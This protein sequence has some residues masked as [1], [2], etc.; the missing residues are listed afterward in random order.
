MINDA[1]AAAKA[2][3]AV[4]A[5]LGIHQTQEREGVDRTTLDLPGSQNDLIKAVHAVG[6]P[7]VVVLINGGPLA[8]EWIAKNVSAI[9]EAFYPG[10]MGGD[11]IADI[12]MGKIS[13]GGR[14]PVT[15]YPS[16]F[17]K[18]RSM[19]DMG[20]RDGYGVTYRYYEGEALWDFGDGLSYT[21]FTYDWSND[22]VS[23]SSSYTTDDVINSPINYTIVVRNTGSMTGDEVVLAYLNGPPYPG[24]PVRELFGFERVRLRPG[25]SATVHFSVPPPILASVDVD[26]RQAVKSGRY[27]VRVGK[28]ER[29]FDLTGE[30][31]V[32]FDLA[33]VKRRQ[34]NPVMIS[35]RVDFVP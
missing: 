29:K 34:K 32:L 23:S 3:D 22:E 7:L 10:E 28:L 4:V 16:N 8:I 13:P 19:F 6:K 20:L 11:A 31:R 1:V 15:V 30:E 2:S 35:E 25:E 26:G 21:T 17:V 14:M 33:A 5:F 27:G 18:Q 9:V 24:G 12:L